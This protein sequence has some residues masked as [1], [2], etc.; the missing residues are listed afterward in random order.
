MPTPRPGHTQATRLKYV[1][2]TAAATT[3]ALLLG[4]CTA[5]G[6]G[7][8][9]GSATASAAPATAQ[10]AEAAPRADGLRSY[11]AAPLAQMTVPPDPDGTTEPRGQRQGEV[12]YD[13]SVQY[14]ESRLWNPAAGRFD[15]VRLRGY[16]GSGMP[17]GAPLV[18]PQVEIYPGETLRMN[19]TNNLP[20]EEDCLTHPADIN[21]P[22]CFNG[23]NMHTHGLW[24][25]PAGNSDN[26]LISINPGVSFQYEYNIPSDHPAGTFW[27]HPHRHGSTS[28][29]VSS[30]MAG[31]L[32]IR[33]VRQPEPGKPGDLDVLLQATDTQSFK[34]RVMLLQQIAYACGVDDKGTVTWDCPGDAPRTI[35]SY[36]QLEFPAWTQSGR[37]TSI[38]GVVQPLIT[39]TEAGQIERWRLVHAG[40]EDTISLEIRA[41]APGKTVTA[42][43]GLSADKADAAIAE[44]CTGAPVPF[45][46]VA[47]DGL[48]MPRAVETEVAT[49]QP[50]YRWDLLVTLPEQGLYCVIDTSAPAAGTVPDSRGDRQ[51]LGFAAAV[52]GKAVPAGRMKEHVQAALIKAADR[53]ITSVLKRDVMAGLEDGLKLGAFVWHK[54]I[55]FDEVGKKTGQ[56]VMFDITKQG[57]YHINGKSY[58]PD[59]VDRTL[60]LGTAEQW[61]LESR[62]VSHPFHIHVNP[63]QIIAIEVNYNGTWVDVSGPDAVDDFQYDKATNTIVR[64]G[65]VDPQYRGLK[66]AWKDTILVKS[67]APGPSADGE[68]FSY[69]ITMRT[70]YQRYIGEFVLHC[71]ILDHEDQG[72]M[73]NVQIVLPDGR[74]GASTGKMGMGGHHH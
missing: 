7:S 39:E 21:T 18:S 25:N 63:F 3:A 64:G 61:Q 73:E 17:P 35:E 74:G 9:G 5:T 11:Q 23:T 29:Q 48:T 34:E 4:A 46:A 54:D 60:I 49:F 72:M 45:Y 37:F 67:L 69:R 20:P 40:N 66:G 52:G 44:A 59:T 19:F 2:P 51:L 36:N 50:G 30:G 38:N 8:A 68:K 53:N 31:A 28:I 12:I 42:L 15:P 70:R 6:G 1:L 71:H 43:M 57:K 47:S 56:Y 32:I 33:G 10:V 22:H 16:R 41:L 65:P 55:S 27:Y 58:D 24:I 62:F 13:L 14:V 26:V